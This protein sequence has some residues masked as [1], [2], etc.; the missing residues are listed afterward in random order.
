MQSTSDNILNVFTKTVNNLTKVN[1]EALIEASNR[2]AKAA[3]LL[4]EAETLDTV[5]TKNNK[6]IS[7]INSILND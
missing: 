1:D 3:Q 6:V 5:I 2:R 7:K 4:S